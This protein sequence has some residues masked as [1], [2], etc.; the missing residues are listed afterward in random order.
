MA[1]SH[2]D[3][4]IVHNLGGGDPQP[5]RIITDGTVR[6][7]VR[8]DG[9]F[10]FPALTFDPAAGRTARVFFRIDEN[11]KQQFCV[12][13]PSGVFQVLATEP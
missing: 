1:F 7:L 11:G 13:F 4:P 3:E 10:E 2:K 5:V 6:L 12:Q 9:T 8:A